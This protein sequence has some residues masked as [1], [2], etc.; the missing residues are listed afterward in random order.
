MYAQSNLHSSSLY[1]KKDGESTDGVAAIR[2]INGN[3]YNESI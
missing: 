1:I 2:I 3:L